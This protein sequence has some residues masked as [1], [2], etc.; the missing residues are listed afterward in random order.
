MI[1]RY[2]TSLA[3][4]F[5][6]TKSKEIMLLA[7]LPLSNFSILYRSLFTKMRASLNQTPQ[8][9]I[10]GKGHTRLGVAVYT[11]LFSFATF[12][13]ASAVA[14]TKT[15]SVPPSNSHAPTALSTAP[16]PSKEINKASIPQDKGTILVVGDSLSA[17]YGLKRGEGWVALL[18]P[19]LKEKNWNAQIAN[20][21][22]SGETTSGGR[23]RID[24]LLQKYKPQVVVIELG[25]N[26][27]LRGLPLATTKANLSYLVEA[28]Q[29]INA[30]VLVVGMEIP[31]NFG[32]QYARDFQAIYPQ[33]AQQYH[34]GL[35]SF[36]LKGVAD[37]P[38]ATELFQS[39]RIHPNAKAHPT[40]LNNI[41]TE[42][43][44][45]L[46]KK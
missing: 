12:M 40:I 10:E 27:A 31:P 39:D 37:I 13:S 38:Q 7:A 4:H 17:E 18:E 32:G 22:V 43:E 8:G 5:I 34:T 19:K 36:M 6:F 33:V 29:K 3:P 16:T 25:A 28:S 44:P 20:V 14:Q 35:V 46:Q 30:K 26:D 24:A 15:L 2:F 41:W 23:S 9:L 45:I 42:L 21:S 11:G 1:F